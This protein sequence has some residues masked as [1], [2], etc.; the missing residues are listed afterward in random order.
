M[1]AKQL[2]DILALLLKPE[3]ADYLCRAI[4]I[5][6]DLINIEEAKLNRAQIA[7]LLNMCLLNRLFEDVPDATSYCDEQMSQG[8][9][10]ILD[11]GAL[12]TVAIQMQN[13][14]AGKEAFSR[15]LEPLGYAM[16]GEYPLDKLKMCGF[17][18]CHRDYPEDISQ[19]FV[20]ELYTDRFSTE[21]EKT[22]W[23]LVYLSKDPLGAQSK[24]LLNQLTEEGTL[25]TLDALSLLEELPNCFGRQ[26]EVPS[27]EQYKTLLA[28]SAE[29]AWIATEG[30]VFNHATDRVQDLD[31]LEQ[32][33]RT[34]GRA[35]KPQIE[36]GR[37]ANIRQTAYRAATVER[38]F[39]EGEQTMTREVPGSFFEFIERGLITDSQTGEER[40]DLRFDSRNAQGIFTMTRQPD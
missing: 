34:K 23:E 18:Y 27:L 11:H 39:A 36:E 7:Q 24:T 12:R 37:N 19:F 9:K 20:S 17:V 14:P 8:R 3:R 28:E 33:E 6:P 29:M 5:H 25:D 40:M 31:A 32:Q 10:I 4:E 21:F 26:H 16:V 1:S 38:Q 15:I 2:G 35:M 22:V 30:N 13:L